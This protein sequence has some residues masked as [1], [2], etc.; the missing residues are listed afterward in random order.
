MASISGISEVD[1]PEAYLLSDR[2]VLPVDGNG[3]WREGARMFSFSSLGCLAPMV[4]R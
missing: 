2:P 3:I 1:T 4:A